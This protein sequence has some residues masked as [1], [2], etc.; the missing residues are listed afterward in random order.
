MIWRIR[1]EFDNGACYQ[2]KLMLVKA[3]NEDD[4]RQKFVDYMRHHTRSDE[5]YVEDSVEISEITGDI[6][7]DVVI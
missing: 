6:L 2:D 1:Y 5:W 7:C 4:A 3:D